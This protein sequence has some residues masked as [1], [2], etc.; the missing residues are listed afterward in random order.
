VVRLFHE[1]GGKSGERGK[2]LA[3]RRKGAK[4]HRQALR[5]PPE[6]TQTVNSPANRQV[7]AILKV[8]AWSDGFSAAEALLHHGADT[9]NRVL[10]ESERARVFGGFALGT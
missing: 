6:L 3:Q 10:P 8:T 1:Q 9:V 5:F 4:K 2:N 7:N